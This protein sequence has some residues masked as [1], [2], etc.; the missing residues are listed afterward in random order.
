MSRGAGAF[1]GFLGGFVLAWGLAIVFY[2]VATEIGWMRD[3]EGGKAM[4]FAFVIG[5]FFGV[6]GGILL[7]IRLARRA[8]S[9]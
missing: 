1:L 5:P 8:P 7:A 9:S 4:A 2:I 6:I 3:R